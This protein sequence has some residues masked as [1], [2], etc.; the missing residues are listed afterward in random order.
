MTLFCYSWAISFAS[1][2]CPKILRKHG[3]RKLINRSIQNRLIIAFYFTQVRLQST[4]VSL[5]PQPTFC[6]KWLF[7]SQI[8]TL[9]NPSQQVTHSLQCTE[10]LLEIWMIWPLLIGILIKCW[11]IHWC[12]SKVKVEV[13]LAVTAVNGSLQKLSKEWTACNNCLSFWKLVPVVYGVNSLWKLSKL[14][15]TLNCCHQQL[16]K[17]VKAVNSMKLLSILLTTWNYCQSCQQLSK[18]STASSFQ[19]L[20]K[21]KTSQ[22]KYQ[23]K[24][25]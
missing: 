6:W 10:D 16:V 14:W 1:S 23:F 21:L 22:L 3:T 17:A 7:P 9:S 19:N 13:V 15:T 20:T 8:R 12:W 18:L 2:A 5:V 24:L 11:W 4:Q 25:I